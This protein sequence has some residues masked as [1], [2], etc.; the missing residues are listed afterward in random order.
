MIQKEL[1][2]YLGKKREKFARFYFLSNDDLLEILSQA[3]DPTAVQPYLKKVFENIHEV[4]FNNQT[5]PKI[6][7]MYS[8]EREKVEFINLLDPNN[9]NVED[10]MGELEEMMKQSVRYALLKSVQ[11]YPNPT[12]TDWVRANPG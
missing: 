9:K 8:E 4:E 10:W 11:T 5:P 3:K 7:A 2:N 6:K 12:R 1:D